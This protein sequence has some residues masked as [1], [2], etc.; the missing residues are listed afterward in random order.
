MGI[1]S[2]ALEA[3]L[4]STSGIRL[5]VRANRNRVRRERQSAATA[6]LPRRRASPC[7]AS[8][9][10]LIDGEIRPF[11]GDYRAP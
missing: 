7:R 8:S 9:P 5:E 2:T 10:G 11:R 6:N 1:I 4:P 3:S